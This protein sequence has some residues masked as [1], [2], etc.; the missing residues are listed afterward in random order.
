VEKDGREETAASLKGK[1]VRITRDTI[2]WYDQDRKTEMA[3]RYEV[4]TSRTPWQVE[5]TCTEGEHKGK[6]VKGIMQLEGDTL[7]ICYAKPDKDAPTTFK[8]A[9]D[10]CCFTLKRAAR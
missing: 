7:R 5:M 4:N 1:Q 9:T 3:A 8:T 2:T 6:K 10:Q